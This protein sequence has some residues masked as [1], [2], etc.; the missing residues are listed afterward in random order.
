MHPRHLPRPARLP[1]GCWHR[2]RPHGGGRP[3]GEPACARTGEAWGGGGGQQAACSCA[4]G[5][6]A[7]L[8]LLASCRLS[9]DNLPIPLPA[10]LAAPR[11]PTL[12]RGRGAWRSASSAPRDRWA[13]QPLLLPGSCSAAA[14]SLPLAACVSLPRKLQ[15]CCRRLDV[16]RGNSSTPPPAAWLLPTVPA[17]QP[18]PRPGHAGGHF[19]G[20]RPAL[21]GVPRGQP[22]AAGHPGC[23]YRCRRRHG[24]R[25]HHLRLLVRRGR[26]VGANARACFATILT[27]PASRACLRPLHGSQ[28]RRC[29]LTPCRLHAP[30]S[31]S[32]PGF[33]QD[34][35]DNTLACKSCIDYPDVG[36]YGQWTYRNGEATPENNE[37]K[38]VPSGAHGA[39]GSGWVWVGWGGM[40]VVV[41]VVVVVVG[42][43]NGEAPPV[44]EQLCKPEGALWRAIRR[45]NSSTFFDVPG[46]HSSGTAQQRAAVRGEGPHPSGQLEARLRPL[47][48]PAPTPC[49]PSLFVAFRLLP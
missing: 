47:P 6:V 14:S 38:P 1:Q 42:G 44:G 4:C 3:G 37:C 45:M 34:T 23:R 9:H 19:R 46:W 12:W 13:P 15:A 22:G 32:P 18:Q 30:P 36:P 17:V 40:V 41:V 5:P 26:G 39:G 48:A 24:T 31:C 8:R 35:R 11:A 27:V 25:R 16:R 10:P 49:T 2:G 43:G 21:P 20:Y 28:R 29:S 7:L 33:W